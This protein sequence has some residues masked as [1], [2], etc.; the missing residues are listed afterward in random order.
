MDTAY[1]FA[2]ATYDP[3]RGELARD[4]R[5]VHLRPQ[6]GAVLASLLD[7]PRTVESKDELLREV[8]P[9]LVV[10]ENSLVQCV[11]EIRRELG[12]DEGAL[13]RTAPRRGYVLEADV[14]ST[15]L[16]AAP[17]N[18]VASRRLALIVMPLANV[19]DD[20]AQSYF[21]EALTDDLTTDLGRIP[22]ALVISR[23]TAYTYRDRAHDVREIGRD[24]GVRYVVEGSV[25]RRGA[26]VVVNLSLSETD[27]GTQVWTER[28][29]GQ[30][31]DLDFLQRAMAGQL[32]NAL[33]TQLFK[34]ESDRL[35]RAAS[36]DADAQDLALRAWALW[37]L[38][39]LKT[40]TEAQRL[41]REALARDPDCTRALLTLAHTLITDIVF[42]VRTDI[43]EV[44]VEVEAVARRATAIDPQHSMAYAPLGT[45]LTYQ[46]RFEEA[47]GIYEAQLERNAN[48][49]FTHVWMGI[50]NLF[51][52][53]PGIAI[54]HFE[55]GIQLNP[56]APALSTHYRNIA[57]AHVHQGN[58]AEALAFAERSVRLPNPWAR[59]YETLAA[60]YGLAG[61]EDDARAAVE[62][63]LKRWPGYSIA[64]HRAEMVSRRPAFLEQRERYLEG[65]R[66]AGLPET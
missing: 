25:R 38:S 46:G 61:L 6:T 8:W 4:G 15:P 34:A 21:A 12:D 48:F 29:E 10:T 19:G 20:P 52:A 22:E 65:L 1:A 47:L 57:V 55:R 45:A 40:N 56:R 43:P 3:K 49:P 63:L 7:R 64:Q 28:F 2:G 37:C 23:N 53:R 17:A 50:T 18:P 54:P 31:S 32:A 24:I 13:V 5:I 59:S 44:A 58:D 14:A 36:G 27:R 51:M 16:P 26:D 39:D 42:R 35:A 30:R 41:A 33:G 60:V 66:R 9:N 11:R 62:V